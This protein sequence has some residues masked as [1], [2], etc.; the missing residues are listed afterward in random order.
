MREM[1]HRT[2]RLW[3]VPIALGIAYLSSVVIGFFDPTGATPNPYNYLE[4]YA[5]MPVP[6][7]AQSIVRV[8]IGALGVAA[9]AA[10]EFGYSDNALPR[11]VDSP[12]RLAVF[13][14]ASAGFVVESLDALRVIDIV[15][16][17]AHHYFARGGAR[18]DVAALMTETIELDRYKLVLA[19]GTTSWVLYFSID[20]LVRRGGDRVWGSIGLVL[21]AS[22]LALLVSMFLNLGG[23][24][25]LVIDAVVSGLLFPLWFIGMGVQ[26][27]RRNHASAR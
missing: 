16:D 4:L 20:L 11:I 6:E 19:G 27:R 24:L 21:V 18:R 25:N 22:L 14:L 9:L 17:M 12:G 15:P 5:E 2:A 3:W 8:A 13:I 7:T 26:L 1:G 10:L 23:F